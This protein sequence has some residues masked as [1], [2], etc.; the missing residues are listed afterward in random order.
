[1]IV[2]RRSAADQPTDARARA[3]AG[4]VLLIALA[5]KGFGGLEAHVLHLAL[6]LSAA[7]RSVAV[8]APHGSVLHARSAR[9]GIS[10]ISIRWLYKVRG[11][12][13]RNYLLTRALARIGKRLNVSIF[14]CNNRFEAPAAMAAAKLLGARCL[15]NYHVPDPFDITILRGID[16]FVSPSLTACKY[17]TE[18][19]SSEILAA[20]RI[21]LLPPVVRAEPFLNLSESFKARYWLQKE[22]GLSDLPDCPIICMVGNMVEDLQHKNYPLLFEALS[23]LIHERQFPVIALLVGDGPASGY[24]HLLAA[25]LRITTAVHFL[26]HLSEQVPGVMRSADLVVLAS[27]HEAFG[28]VLVEAGFVSRPT[29]A[30]RNTG[31]EQIIMDRE[32]GLLF[33]NG[34]GTSLAD[35]M[36]V[37]LRQPKYGAEL[38]ANAKRHTMALFD[39][40][41]VTAKYIA[42]YDLLLGA[43]A[44]AAAIAAS[45]LSVD[46]HGPNS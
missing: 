22:F 4:R 17:V 8:L 3:Q 36:E 23:I 20:S 12:S 2:A 35:A 46:T 7:K 42:L 10:C 30:A 31:A 27:R 5:G 15:L 9:E 41:I 6:Q 33:E 26:G 19:C 44:E 1:M 28:M 29:V 37:I 39:P 34:D 40:K 13:L 18:N 38:G 45:S 21:R 43:R 32:T 24:L 16:A 11:T 25:Q 14:H